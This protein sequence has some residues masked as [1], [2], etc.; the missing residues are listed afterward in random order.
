MRKATSEGFVDAVSVLAQ[1]SSS[2]RSENVSSYA[3][4]V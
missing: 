1:H 4:V 3:A 2:I